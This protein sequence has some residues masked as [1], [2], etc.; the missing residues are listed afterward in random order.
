MLGKE[1]R[2]LGLPWLRRFLTN[3]NDATRELAAAGPLF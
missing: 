2:N 1:N 3:S